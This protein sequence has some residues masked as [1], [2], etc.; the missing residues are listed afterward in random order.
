M[1]DT[2]EKQELRALRAGRAPTRIGEW[3]LHADLGV[4]RGDDGEVRLNPKS[5]HVL[6]VLLDAGDKGVSRD[7]LLDKVWGANY[8]SDN[9]IS[10]AMADL[11][12][13]F[14]E[15]AGEQKTIRTLPKFGYQF[16][17]E[18]GAIGD[19]RERPASRVPDTHLKRYRHH[20]VVGSIVLLASFLLPRLLLSPNADRAPA[21]IL[22]GAQPLTSAPG[23]E[24]QPR[25]VAGGDWVVH[26]IMRRDRADWDLF[27]VALS[28]GTTQPVAVT[29]GVQE[30]GPAPSPLGDEIAYVRLSAE[31]CDVVVQSIALGVPE[32]IA[33]C[34]QRFPTL[35]DWS[36]A[37]N[38]IAYTAAQA[39][40]PDGR[41]RIYRVDRTNGETRQIS[42]NVSQ[43]G[44]D[45][46]PR[47]SPDGNTLAFLRGEPQPD[48]RT[49][50]W[51][52]DVASG[53]ETPLTELPTQLGGM[54]WINNESL[55]YSTLDAGEMQGRL[56]NTNSGEIRPLEAPGFI[57]PEYRAGEGTLIVAEQR[58]DRDLAVLELDR[59]A[60]IVAQSTSDDHHGRFSP[61]E[62]WL[63][64]VS[65]RSGYDELWIH[66]TDGDASRRLTRFDGATVRYPDWHPDG[67]SILITVQNDAG[68][69][70]YVVDIVSG[71]AVEVVTTFDDITTPRW[72]PGNEG[73]IAGCRDDS[74]WGICV[75]GVASV[76]RVVE[77]LYRPNP[78]GSGDVYAVNDTGTL[79]R[80]SLQDGSTVKILDG[81]PGNGRYGWEVTAESLY[82]FAGG[83]TGN[84]GRLMRVE[85][86]GGEPETLFSGSM[87]VADASISVGN[88]SGRILITLFQT[89][90]DDLVVYEGL[91]FD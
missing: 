79:Y 58:S 14:G 69:R 67:Q 37:G 25:I 83:D 10:R 65:R 72:L 57:H 12:S 24:H 16:I 18:Q 84:S 63:A 23:L 53:A 82:F 3:V 74:G 68:E 31:S 52:V 89:S 8:P 39:D 29:P 33:S 88:Q 87:P 55:I 47:F 43:T 40:D 91:S 42:S 49:T 60:T 36:P 4:L 5:L 30:H 27:R 35:A 2:A 76:S 38:Q 85:I 20:Y 9:V 78:S 17:A 13:A 44:T 86:S 48:H 59:D 62:K 1:T 34:T 19:E 70:L 26:A 81:M 73:W 41:R 54:A 71:A 32:P 51:I 56:V 11:R 45:F 7:E 75:G 21:M 77:G 28:D 61:D 15:S 22:S 90:S 6:L 46:Y 50:L 80:F 64:F 66:S